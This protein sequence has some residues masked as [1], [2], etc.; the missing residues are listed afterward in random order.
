[1]S[2]FSENE[3]LFTMS[4]NE[5]K[6]RMLTKKVRAMA[7]LPIGFS[8]GEGIPVSK[9]AISTAEELI[10]LASE[11]ELDAD[12]FP[13]MDGG[14]AVAVYKKEERVE[15][16][17]SRDGNKFDCRIEHGIGF[18]FDDVVPPMENVNFSKAIEQILKLW[19]IDEEIWKLYE[20]STSAS[21]TE[22]V[23]DFEIPPIGTHPRQ[24]QQILQ[25]V[26]GGTQSSMLLVPA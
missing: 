25:M 22:Q 14:C 6:R 20:S 16:S 18:Q 2:F 19:M 5:A 15:V 1:M 9:S 13:N 12:V 3:I 23:N 26:R 17:I 10:V 11:L 21:S 7:S 4:G 24:G 8:H